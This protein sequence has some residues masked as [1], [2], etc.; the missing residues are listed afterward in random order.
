[1]ARRPRARRMEGV[2]VT[3]FLYTP[4]GLLLCVAF[5]IA[6]VMLAWRNRDADW[7]VI[8]GVCAVTMLSGAKR[9]PGLLRRKRK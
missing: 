3:D 4:V 5:V 2:L 1:M 9:L 6:G 8:V 7:L